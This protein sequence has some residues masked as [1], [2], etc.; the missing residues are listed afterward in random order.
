M[1]RWCACCACCCSCCSWS[2]AHPQ[3]SC[4][5]CSFGRSHIA[6]NFLFLEV[7]SLHTPSVTVNCVGCYRI[8]TVILHQIKFENHST[9]NW[10]NHCFRRFPRSIGAGSSSRWFLRWRMPLASST[11]TRKRF[12]TFGNKLDPLQVDNASLK[13][14][15]CLAGI[16]SEPTN[17]NGPTNCY[18]THWFLLQ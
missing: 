9:N 1:L 11:K 14:A 3:S 5:C 2:H 12:A 18:G 15:R 17:S 8:F 6:K 10:A 7:Y 16:V 13:S 4:H